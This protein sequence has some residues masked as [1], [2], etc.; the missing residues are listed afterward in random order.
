MVFTGIAC[1]RARVTPAGATKRYSFTFLEVLDR[2]DVVDEHLGRIFR[3]AFP[4]RIGVQLDWE[5]SLT[6]P[7]AMLTDSVD[8]FSV[9]SASHTFIA[10]EAH[11]THIQGVRV[12]IFGEEL[13]STHQQTAKG[14]WLLHLLEQ[15]TTDGVNEHFVHQLNL[16]QITRT[17]VKVLQYVQVNT[18]LVES[19]DT[20]VFGSF[21]VFTETCQQQTSHTVFFGEDQGFI[22]EDDCVFMVLQIQTLPGI[23]ATRIYLEHL[24]QFV[25]TV[26]VSQHDASGNRFP[27]HLGFA[28][29]HRSMRGVQS[30]H[31]LKRTDRL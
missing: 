3:Y 17:D 29:F 8:H 6:D 13:S 15:F 5:V 1:H 9:D 18:F 11:E 31:G 19:V 14:F 25:Q 22:T 10:F 7:R 23:D 24:Q 12:V 30:H 28:E 27:V 4:N 21:L 26:Q 2:V 20:V 16:T